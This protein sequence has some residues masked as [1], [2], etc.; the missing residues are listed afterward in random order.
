MGVPFLPRRLW[1]SGNVWSSSVPTSE[2]TI[3]YTGTSLM[4]T[5]RSQ[6]NTMPHPTVRFRGASMQ[7]L[8]A[9]LDAEIDRAVESG[10]C[11]RLLSSNQHFT[12]YVS[13]PVKLFN[14]S[15]NNDFS[16][17]SGDLVVS[18][19]DGIANEVL[20]TLW[21]SLL[22][23]SQASQFLVN[24]IDELSSLR[25]IYQLQTRHIPSA[26]LRQMEK[27]GII[28]ALMVLQGL[29]PHPLDPCLLQ[30]VIY[31]FDVACLHPAIVGEWHPELRLLLENWNTAGHTGSLEP[32]QA[33][34]ASYLSV[35][36][37]SSTLSLS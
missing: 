27:F 29:A 30:L 6:A 2:C 18:L 17:D 16:V 1:D 25:V 37:V 35:D 20:Y 24:R 31:N 11:T 28:V 14:T 4:D 3:S 9:A 5:V 12:M 19:E 36:D 32:F 8:V 34:L 26:R 15:T 22:A 10:D 23:P 13:P 21:Q 7:E 33:H